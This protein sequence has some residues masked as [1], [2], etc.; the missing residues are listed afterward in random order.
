[1]A[2]GK[3]YCDY[4]DKQFQDTPSARKRHLRG[5]PHQIAK[6]QWFD[7]FSIPSQ[8]VCRYFAE[9]VNHNNLLTLHSLRVGAAGGSLIY[10]I[11]C[12][13]G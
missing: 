13:T 10:I 1:M 4:C 12:L 9:T 6:K 3:Y 8:G 7:S 5:I 11:S 2:A